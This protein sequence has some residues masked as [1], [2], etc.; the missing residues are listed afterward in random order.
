M[1]QPQSFVHHEYPY[2]VCKLKK[3]FYR[4]MQAPKAWI[5]KVSTCLTQWDFKGSQLDT[6]MMTF[7]DKGMIMILLIYVDDI[8][9]TQNNVDF[10][11]IIIQ[12]LHSVF[13]L[14][15]VGELHFFRYLSKKNYG[16]FHLN[17]QKYIKL[18]EKA[19]YQKLDQFSHF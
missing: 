12:K 10:I 19:Q 2:Y 1:H 3:E 15:D 18:L 17:Q 6:S 13:A 14:N 9:V 7:T 11:Q 16:G 4:L 5:T 8:I